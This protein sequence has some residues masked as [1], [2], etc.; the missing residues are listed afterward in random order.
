M[1]T[2]RLS[3]RA[4]YGHGDELVNLFKEQFPSMVK[5]TPIIGARIYT[6][7]TG[8][9]F[10]VIVESDFP[11]L[12]A[13]FVFLKADNDDSAAKEFQAWFARMVAVTDGGDRQVLNLEK[14]V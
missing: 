4:K 10:S 2:E 5:G 12:D 1:I 8:A 14:L 11:D 3:F 7:F 13:Y 9:M 6:D